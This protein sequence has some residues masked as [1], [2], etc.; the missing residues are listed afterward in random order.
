MRGFILGLAL[1]TLSTAC[2]K[3]R[4]LT[5]ATVVAARDAYELA[6][7]SANDEHLLVALERY[8]AAAAANPDGPFSGEVAYSL[9]LIV[10]DLHLVALPPY[11]K[12][13]AEAAALQRALASR[14]IEVGALLPFA[15]RVFTVARDAWQ[16]AD[17]ERAE[18]AIE[19]SRLR[20]RILGE[21][22]DFAREPATSPLKRFVTLEALLEKEQKLLGSGVPKEIA[23]RAALLQRVTWLALLPF[24]PEKQGCAISA[25]LVKALLGIS[26]DAESPWPTCLGAQESEQAIVRARLTRAAWVRL[27]E[28]VL[29]RPDS[30]LR[31]FAQRLLDRAPPEARR[32][33]PR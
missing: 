21:L 2:P 13:A 27:E 20:E 24:Q 30:P 15:V 28:F 17:R 7:K 22:V 31:A 10:L 11:F 25:Y 9:G 32:P 12:T 23:E 16:D 3:P 18:R 33:V 29:D 5:P 14:K 1:A 26:A 4:T 6:R 19:L 8:Q